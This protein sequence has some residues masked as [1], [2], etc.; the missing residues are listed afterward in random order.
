MRRRIGELLVERGVLR[1]EALARALESARTTGQRLASQVVALDL[2]AE[3]RVVEV[4]AAAAG[5]PGVDL[6]RSVLDPAHLALIPRQVAE[7]ERILP[8]GA[9]S[10]RLLLAMADPHNVRVVAEV[11]L[12][13]GL[14][15]MPHVAVAT[16]LVDVIAEAYAALDAGRPAWA[17]SEVP[18]G[19]LTPRLATHVAAPEPAGDELEI[20]IG[21][22]EDDE[23][24]EEVGS[25]SAREGPR[26]VLV[27]D[28]E[29]EILTLVSKALE[30]RG[31]RV[32]QARRGQ[33]ALQRV[34]AL[35][36]DLVLLDAN[37]PEIHGFD[38]CRKIKSNRRF[39]RTPVIMMTAVYRGWRFAHDIRESFG[40]DDYLEKPFRLDDLL[41]RVDHHLQRAIGE[42]ERDKEQAEKLYRDGLALLEK[43][44]AR[45][46]AAAFEQSLQADGFSARA[47][48]QLGRALQAA[49]DVWGAIGAYER[50]VDLRP[51]LFPALRS[52]AALYQQKGFRRK[53][54]EAWE[55]AIPAAPDDATRQKI[56]ASLLALL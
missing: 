7:L 1:P 26:L 3:G 45:E 44:Q 47:H 21:S 34:N 16:R 20:E 9:E 5:V 12:I 25:V 31:Y 15:V 42:P 17:G 52:L 11:Q 6:S 13:S 14:E 53:A 39:A 37:L 2:A 30:K 46:A 40:A 24:G 28:D 32:E 36:P 29:E 33:E 19:D 50:S 54:I 22:L 23:E 55:R 48:Y 10:G 8:V 38:I 27:V 43:G 51:D 49:G 4:L 56:K 41:R 35:M 18:P